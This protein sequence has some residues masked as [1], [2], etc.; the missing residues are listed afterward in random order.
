MMVIDKYMKSGQLIE[1][2]VFMEG[3][4]QEATAIHEAHP[5]YLERTL[6]QKM[7]STYISLASC[8]I[9]IGRPTYILEMRSVALRNK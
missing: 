2:P 7:S 8:A 3:M 6:K 4:I 1:S 9:K 5:E